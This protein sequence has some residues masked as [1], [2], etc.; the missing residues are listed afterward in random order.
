[1]YLPLRACAL[2]PYLSR[3]HHVV[4][5]ANSAAPSHLVNLRL[6]TSRSPSVDPSGS[7]WVPVAVRPLVAGSEYSSGTCASLSRPDLQQV[8][9]LVHGGTCPGQLIRWVLTPSVLRPQALIICARRL[10]HSTASAFAAANTIHSR[11]MPALDS[12]VPS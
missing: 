4:W 5:C 6:L 9:E 1:M 12:P 7:S 2:H 10:L 3:T 8:P 11:L